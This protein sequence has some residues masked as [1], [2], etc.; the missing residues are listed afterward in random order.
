MAFQSKL[1]SLQPRRMQFQKRVKLLS[2]GYI[3]PDAFPNGEITVFPWDMNVDDWLA[4]RIRKGVRDTVL[5]DLCAHLCDL[6]GCPLDSFIVGD[7]NTVLLVARAIRYDSV[8]QYE[9]VCP[10]CQHTTTES[11]RVPD[12]LGRVGEKTL[13]YP[14]FDTITLSDC[15][16]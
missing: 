1:K 5:F 11:I 8:V 6:N 7:V 4:E 10:K 13:E 9:A 3:K 15:G 2:G 12:E 14:G 16:D